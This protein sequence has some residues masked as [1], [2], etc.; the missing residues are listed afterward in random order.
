MTPLERPVVPEVNMIRASSVQEWATP[1]GSASGAAISS[2]SVS[3]GREGSGP[4]GA[5]V[6]ST[7]T[8]SSSGSSGATSARRSRWVSAMNRIRD[9][10][11]LI[12]QLRKSPLY[13]V[14]IGLMTAPAFR[15]PNQTGTNSSQLGSSTLTDS[16]GRRRARAA[17]WRRGSPAR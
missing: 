9:S 2:S 3:H 12:V 11:R 4:A 5:P 17:R 7:T 16:P 13:A 1:S 10:T 15:I 6:R 14:L 8:L